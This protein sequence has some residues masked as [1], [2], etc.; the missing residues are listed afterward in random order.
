MDVTIIHPEKNNG[1]Q[2]DLVRFDITTSAI[3]EMQRNYMALKINDIN[4]KNGYKVVF[5]ARQI[6][7][8]KRILVKKTADELETPYKD[9]INA[10]RAEEKRILSLLEPIEQHLQSEEDTYLKLIEDQKAQAA[11]K[12]Q[13]RI[14]ERIDKLSQYG[15]RIDYSE[16][17]SMTDIAFNDVLKQ[18]EIKH[19]EEIQAKAEQERLKK[20]QE[21]K[22]KQQQE[23][24]K[25]KQDEL[26]QQ[27]NTFL[28]ERRKAKLKE[29]KE[30]EVEQKRLAEE[31]EKKR[32][33]QLKPDK[34]KLRSFIECLA[35]IEYP[36]CQDKMAKQFINEAKAEI[37]GIRKFF[38]ETINR[39]SVLI[40]SHD[41]ETN[42][43]IVENGSHAK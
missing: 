12:E 17:K 32:V 22:F 40:A 9:K 10:I 39:F 3:E 1:E 6:V 37:E 31:E 42:S 26:L 8:N 13:Q 43:I 19:N 33:E 38:I 20:E 14:Q 2:K 24:L 4:D 36:E 30:K 35:K 16:I 15:Y 27:Q 5:N 7:K 41:T 29:Q 18:A 21:E 25:K 23:E 34:E 28:E 11:R